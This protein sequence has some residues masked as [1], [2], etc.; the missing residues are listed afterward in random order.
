MYHVNRFNCADN[1][2]AIEKFE[3]CLAQD[4]DNVRAYIG[5]Y[6]CYSMAY[7]GR[8][9]EN[10]MDSFDKARDYIRRA[11]MLDPEDRSAL[12]FHAEM[13]NYA[14]E[15]DKTRFVAMFIYDHAFQYQN[16]GYA[17][18][19]AWVLFLLIV[20]L[21]LLAFRISQRHVYYAGR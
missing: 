5:L 14:G 9:L 1:A 4:P 6:I 17:S 19:V 3:R 10:H 21:T 2:I 7:F 8:W 12:L 18:A 20:G 15:Q 11:L 16:V 13:L